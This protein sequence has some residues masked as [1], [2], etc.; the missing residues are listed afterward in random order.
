MVGC[1]S[2][3][4]VYVVVIV[5]SGSSGGTGDRCYRPGGKGDVGVR[6]Y[7]G[8]FRILLICVVQFG[9]VVE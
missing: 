7:G 3:S 1:Y 2:G 9:G 8:L 5:M 4:E 6:G